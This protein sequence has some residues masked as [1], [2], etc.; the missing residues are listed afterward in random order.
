[1]NYNHR[2]DKIR[3][4]VKQ[5]SGNESISAL[6]YHNLAHTESVVAN[7]IRIADFYKLNEKETFVVTA[8]AWFHDTGYYSGEAKDHE[9]RGADLAANFL[10]EDGIP[11]ELVT[12]VKGC[13]LATVVPQKPKNLLEEIVC[14]ADLFHLGTT[15]FAA[16]NK[17]MRQEAEQRTGTKAD[18]AA[19]REST[20]ELM[21]NHRYHTSY[22][23]EL[24]EK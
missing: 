21:E 9:R 14:D 11:E 5:F 6:I 13:I 10:K 23:R 20:I 12:Q 2:L 17:L 22:C 8:A 1:M 7:A 19:W 15:E 3:H 4:H 18:K 16:R 24:L